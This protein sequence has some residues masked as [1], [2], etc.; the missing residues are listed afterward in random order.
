MQR[1]AFVKSM[2]VV[3]VGA[4]VAPAFALANDEAACQLEGGVGMKSFGYYEGLQPSGTRNPRRTDGT[5]HQMPCISEA[6]LEAGEEKTFNFWHGHS[7]LHTFTVTVEDFEML[8]AGED[9]EIYTSIVDGHRHALRISPTEACG[10][11]A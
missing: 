3:G 7:R 11:T 10:A 6:D 9:V 8:N 2:W 4:Y 1:R 5:Y